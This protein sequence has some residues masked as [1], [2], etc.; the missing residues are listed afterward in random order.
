MLHLIKH[1]QRSACRQ[2][3]N[4]QHKAPERRSIGKTIRVLLIIVLKSQQKTFNLIGYRKMV[5]DLQSRVEECLHN[6]HIVQVDFFCSVHIHCGRGW[7]SASDLRVGGIL[8]NILLPR[9]YYINIKV[10]FL[11]MFSSHSQSKRGET[12]TETNTRAVASTTTFCMWSCCV[13]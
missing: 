10:T 7:R 12:H 9:I 1:T 11:S 6:I 3:H 2:N 8:S 5:C 13:Q 4:K